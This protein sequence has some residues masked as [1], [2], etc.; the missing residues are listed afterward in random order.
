[1]FRAMPAYEL[2]RNYLQLYN[3]FVVGHAIFT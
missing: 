2:N 3:I 1:M